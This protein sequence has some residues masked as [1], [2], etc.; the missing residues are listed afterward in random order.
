MRNAQVVLTFLLAGMAV[1]LQGCLAVVVG[2]GAAG[3][4]AYVKGDLEAVEP[5][6][7]DTVYQATLKAMEQ[8]KLSVSKKAMDAMS[9]VVIARDSDDRKVTIK[10]GATVEG[11]TK[12]SIRV[13]IWGSETKSQFIYDQIKK[14]LQ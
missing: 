11:A 8:L 3:T 13:G 5:K 10:L 7:I 6:D 12:L 4:V 14:N 1:L 9:A 2:A